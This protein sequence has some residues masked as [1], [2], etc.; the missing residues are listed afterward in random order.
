M[1]TERRALSITAAGMTAFQREDAE[2]RSSEENDLRLFDSAN[3][4]VFASTR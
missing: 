4:R 3:L 1:T 2:A